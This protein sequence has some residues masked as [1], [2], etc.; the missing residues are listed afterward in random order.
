MA[1][2]APFAD[3]SA[4]PVRKLADRVHV[5]FSKF[6]DETRGHYYYVIDALEIGDSEI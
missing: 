2:L 3:K 6:W 5:S 1:V 4:E